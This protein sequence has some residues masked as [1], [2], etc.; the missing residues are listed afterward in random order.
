MVPSEASFIHGD[1]LAKLGRSGWS[2]KIACLRPAI[3]PQA[4]RKSVAMN[5]LKRALSKAQ[6]LGTRWLH[7]TCELERLESSGPDAARAIAG[8]VR[9][10]VSGELSE[11]EAEWSARIERVRQSVVASRDRI[12]ARLVNG[13]DDGGPGTGDPGAIVLGP[14]ARISSK[15]RAW[16][17][18]LHQLIRRLRPEICLELGACVGISTAYQAAAL[19]LNGVGRLTSLEGNP[20]LAAVASG[21]L[22]SLDLSERVD[23]RVGCFEKSLPAALADLDRVDFAFIDGHHEEDA[24]WEYFQEILPHLPDGA[25]LLFDDIDWTAGMERA[26][27]RIRRDPSLAA[28]V[29][30][31]KIGICIVDRRASGTPLQFRAAV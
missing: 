19:E 5:T 17:L 16:C 9:A 24:T 15:R 12:A 26:W 10:A 4:Y 31:V 2:M 29:D 14:Y 13:P 6:Q 11:P 22:E 18:L 20:E 3:L 23:L 1:G 30:M 25:V 28:A 8:A 21:H 27:E 7:N